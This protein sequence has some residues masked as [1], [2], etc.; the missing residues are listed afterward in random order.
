MWIWSDGK[1][2]TLKNL[3][4][5]AMSKVSLLPWSFKFLSY[6]LCISYKKQQETTW[7]QYIL[8]SLVKL[9]AVLIKYINHLKEN[10][11]SIQQAGNLNYFPNENKIVNGFWSLPIIWFIDSMYLNCCGFIYYGAELIFAK[12]GKWWVGFNAICAH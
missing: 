12:F 1:I 2:C 7:E 5:L 8:V 11:S 10:F 3:F 4:I 6:Y 9:Q